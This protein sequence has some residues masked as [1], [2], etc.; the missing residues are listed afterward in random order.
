MIVANE[1]VID[2][3]ATATQVEKNNV[4]PSTRDSYKNRLTDLILWLYENNY[5]GILSTECRTRL[6]TAMALDRQRRSKTLANCRRCA[7]SLLE[8]LDRNDSNMS[9][10]NIVESDDEQEELLTYDVI[11]QFFSTKQKVVTVDKALAMTFRQKLQDL[12]SQEGDEVVE[13]VPMNADE[14]GQVRVAVRLEASTYDG[15]R[16]A[17]SF[18]YKESGVQMRDSMVTNFGRYI[19]GSKRINLAAKQTLGLKITEGKSHMTVP[20]YEKACEIFFESSKPEHVFAH[21]F[22]VLDWNLMKRAENVVE[23]KIAHVFFREDALVFIFAKSKSQQDG[24]EEYL[25]PWHV[26][27]NPLKPHICPVLA[28]ARFLFTFPETFSGNKPLFEGKNSYAR[29]QKVFSQMLL[30]HG[31]VFRE[32]GVEPSELGTHSA[33]KGVGTL[34]AAGCTVAPPIVSICLRMGW[35]LGGVLGRYFK[36]ADAGDMHCGRT[37]AMQDPMRK[38]FAVCRPYFDFTE[39]EDVEMRERLKVELGTWLNDRLPTNT[40]TSARH[41]ARGLFASVCFHHKFLDDTLH[42]KS[43]FRES[44]FFK[45]IPVAFTERSRI[46]YPWDATKDT[47]KFTGIPP[48]TTLLAKQEELLQELKSLREAIAGQITDELNERGVGCT[49]FYTHGIEQSIKNLESNLKEHYDTVVGQYNRE[50]DEMMQDFEDAIENYDGEEEEFVVTGTLE[51]PNPIGITVGIETVVARQQQRKRRNQHSFSVTK[52]RKVTAGVV[53]GKFTVLPSDFQFPTMS[54]SQLAQNWFIGN[55]GRMIVPYKRLKA[56]DVHHVKGGVKIRQKISSFMK[57]VEFYGRLEGCWIEDDPT[58]AKVNSLTGMVFNTYI[59]GIY[60]GV[61][62][63]RVI[64]GTWA[65]WLRKMNERGA[66]RPSREKM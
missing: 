29:Y 31:N 46:A 8:K 33:R 44:L 22:L 3:V 12:T 55:N 17:I 53:H 48:H 11:A 9:P 43:T 41:L 45:D 27:A 13:E 18:L 7:K 40:P 63:S 39:I 49:Q 36:R 34:V 14:N 10:I 35:A 25:G 1:A 54:C 61:N 32:L 62:D 21:A 59:Y 57:V 6:A 37:A 5:A 28:L 52:K 51:D 16:S 20:V 2:L 24:K 4:G 42:E 60:G 23:A 30:D 58:V 19:K 65:S 38:E 56:S 47:P 15:F 26:Y 66:F 64:R 50:R